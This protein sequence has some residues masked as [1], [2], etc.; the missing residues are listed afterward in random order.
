[1]REKCAAMLTI[2]QE[3][4]QVVFR[5][6]LSGPHYEHKWWKESDGV[7]VVDVAWPGN[8][9]AGDEPPLTVHVGLR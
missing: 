7:I 3:P 5:C 4:E 9:E 2:V 1:M 6:R 8:P